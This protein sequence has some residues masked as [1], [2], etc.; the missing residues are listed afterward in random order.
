[1]IRWKSVG[2]GAAAFLAAHLIETAAWSSWFAGNSFAPWFLNSSRAGAFTILLLSLM[3]ALTA[4]REVEEAIVRGI[5]VGLGAAAVMVVVLFVVGPG[6]LFPIALAIGLV[7][8]VTAGVVGALAGAFSR[9]SARARRRH[10][11]PADS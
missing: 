3:A 6:T 9:G 4:T 5:N 10:V 2:F 8:V 1:M 7:V 11:P